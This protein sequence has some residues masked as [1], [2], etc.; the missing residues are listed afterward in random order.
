MTPKIVSQSI[1]LKVIIETN[2]TTRVTKHNDIVFDIL[3][4]NTLLY[5]NGCDYYISSETKGFPGRGVEKPLVEGVIAGAQ[6]AFNENLGTNIALVR[7]IIRNP[8]L[9]T[10]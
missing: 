10:E 8:D 1:F 6:E 2:M 5:I 7:K 4:G 9:V 3:S